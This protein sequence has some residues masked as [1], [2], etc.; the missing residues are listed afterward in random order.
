MPVVRTLKRL[1]KALSLLSGL[2]AVFLAL[3]FLAF[4]YLI[5]PRLDSY[6]PALEKSLSQMSERRVT[7]ARLSGHWDGVAPLLEMS[8][9]SIANPGGVALT[10]DHVAVK[11]SWESLL[12][13][14][15]RLA[16]V[17]LDGPSIELLRARNNQFY[18]NGFPLGTGKSDGRL[19]NLLISQRRI[20]IN[21]ARLG[22][23]DAYNGFP[24][25]GL[26][27]GQLVLTHGWLGHALQVSGRPTDHPGNSVE[28]AVNWRGDDVRDWAH[29]SGSAQG[30]VHGALAGTW[31]QYL[32]SFGTL[33]TG[34][35]SGAIDIAFSG[36]GIDRVSADFKLQ[37]ASY[38][39]PTASSGTVVIP[40]IG[41]KLNVERHGERYDIDASD[42]TLSSSTGIA[43][44]HSH[45]HGFWLAGASGGG[46]LSLDN[47]DLL[48][49]TP[50]VHG[51][52]IDRN[53]L[54][55]RFA[56]SGHL[57][58][59]KLAWSGHLAA[60]TRYRVS[61]Q[62]RQL[63]WKA[64]GM[65]PGVSG[66][67]GSVDF[68][69]AGGQLTLDMST[70][71]VRI[72]PVFPRPLDFAS[73]KAE[74]GWRVQPHGVAVDFRD[75][76]FS[77]AA[78]AG[79][80]AGQYRY[81]GSGAGTIDLTAS[82]D[83]VD[84]VRVPDYLPYVVGHDTMTWL[85]QALRGGTLTDATLKLS[86]EL[87]RFPFKGGRGGEFLVQGRVR[88]G[89]LAYQPGWPLL[90]GIDA[91]L[92]FHNESMLI[93]GN[94]VSTVGVPLTGVKVSIPDLGAPRPLLLV[95]GQANGRVQ[96]MLAFTRKSPVD[97]WLDG[98]TGS[99]R[100]S[101]DARLD[102]GLK[103]PLAGKSPVL[104]HGDIR[105]NDNGLRFTRL[106]L[107]EL[108]HVGGHLVF[109]EHGVSSPGLHFDAFGGA[110]TLKA[111][112]DAAGVMRFALDGNAD[113]AMVMARYVP[114]LAPY[115]S[116]RSPFAARF[117]VHQ[118]LESLQVTSPLVGT[119]LTLP[120]PAA[121]P[122]VL[123]A[124]LTLNL[125]DAGRAGT[126]LDFTVGQLAAGRFRLGA[127]GTMQA[128]QVAIG[129]PLQDA[130]PDGLTLRI[131]APAIDLQPWMALPDP[132]PQGT[133]MQ[134]RL[135]LDTPLLSW[136]EMQLHG[137]K[138]ALNQAAGVAAWHA[139]LSSKE[140]S[141][142][143]D[144][145]PSGNGMVRARMSRVSIDAGHEPRRGLTRDNS[146]LARLPAL[147]VQ[148]ADFSV[149]G[150]RLGRL[151]MTARQQGDDWVLSPFSLANPDGRLGGSLSVH[152]VTGTPSV[153]GHFSIESGNVG[154]LLDRFGY[155]DTFYKG[156]GRVDSDLRW[157]G[158]L[159]DFNVAHV[160]GRIALDLKNGR[161]AKVDPGVAR[162]LGVLSLQ[163]L[164]RRIRLD[165][166]DVFSEGFAFDE[167]K[168]S[169]TASAGL[170]ESD[171]LNMKGPAADVT[172]KGNVN[173]GTDQQ[174]L[175]VHVEPHI[176][177]SVA[178][179][180]GAALINP[181]IGVAALAAQKVL[182]DPFGKIFSV[183]YLLTGSLT[184]PVVKKLGASK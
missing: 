96:D 62:F 157:P 98:F 140:M 122:A 106:P 77:D 66:V 2:A 161:F 31:R 104:V 8:G 180:T 116:G 103:I 79:R 123:A 58:S 108:E 44:E 125:Q 76:R 151:E 95:D 70:S 179:A 120:A 117:T 165:F 87:D 141:G 49:L 19:N 159:A 61:T 67:S 72:D 162:L 94:S 183:D 105:F 178:L 182:Q 145:F 10:L 20:E 136:G 177:E 91:T 111:D 170:F 109:S 90:E 7:I 16:L 113:S 163:S 22:W 144:Y 4:T 14:S 3:A 171:N 17:R 181:V 184:E 138:L 65:I 173:L 40:V 71:Q 153:D 174:Q 167:L 134:L 43:F 97:G 39:A 150:A 27:H 143:I 11:P 88:D 23:Q 126:R 129:R 46:E 53:P 45:I 169:A 24:R 74:I 128:G 147:D 15:P 5:L 168:G 18:L 78:L 101:G 64:F 69:Q 100:A 119:A 57:Q 132:A 85:R 32:A 21:N 155:R 56:P 92:S 41:G 48:H 107:P 121:K 137:L 13:M 86:G 158:T 38:A 36:G 82:I 149:H 30:R 81:S 115:T 154:K 54:F 164:P 172:I 102:L 29:W 34:E 80:L 114:E 35:G 73:L 118:G 12:V 127:S 47:V 93:V 68:D 160:S 89:R 51:L 124:P 152:S 52:G 110:F 6:R 28:V 75:V 60:P 55:S 59:L 142:D 50:L 25:V 9:L 130:M 139:A 33:R 148:V 146:G 42:L 135:D 84:A 63:A 37:N 83:R 131:A 26:D 166:T 112:S 1:L 99:L 133:P 175:R 176:A 156:E